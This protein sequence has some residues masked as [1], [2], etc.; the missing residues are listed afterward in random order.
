MDERKF[1]RLLGVA[2][3]ALMVGSFQGG[4][5]WPSAIPAQQE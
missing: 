5:T 4:A 3:L 1:L 2:G